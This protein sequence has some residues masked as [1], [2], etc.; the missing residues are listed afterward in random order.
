MR[1]SVVFHLTRRHQPGYLW[2][3]RIDPPPYVPQVPS[4][5][6]QPACPWKHRIDPPPYVLQ[7]AR[8]QK[9]V[10]QQNESGQ[11]MISTRHQIL[12]LK[13]LSTTQMK[14]Y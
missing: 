7:A 10:H 8:V 5:Q 6:H 9:L 3:H 11:P 4:R 13:S 14:N 1:Q 2:K 12:H